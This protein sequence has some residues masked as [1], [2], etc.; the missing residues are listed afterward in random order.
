V[1]YGK[2]SGPVATVFECR[3]ERPRHTRCEA[4]HAAGAFAA[5]GPKWGRCSL[6]VHGE[7]APMRGMGGRRSAEMAP[8]PKNRRS[9]EGDASGAP[10]RSGGIPTG[11]AKAVVGPIPGRQGHE[12]P[13]RARVSLVGSCCYR[14]FA[15]SSRGLAEVWPV[16]VDRG[17]DGR[18]PRRAGDES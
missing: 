9:P 1:S 7:S 14:G 18:M 3:A 15:G 8:R 5:A 13:G 17:R 12:G 6:D 10:E 16:K 4:R 2:R 11:F